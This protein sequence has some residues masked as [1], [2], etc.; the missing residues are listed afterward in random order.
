MLAVDQ[1]M[2]LRERKKQRTRATLTAAALRLFEEQGYERTTI[3]EIAAAADVSTRTFF[4]YFAGKDDVVF[5]DD[6]TERERMLAVVRACAPRQS[7]VDTL[8]SVV[9]DKLSG[10]TDEVL[11]LVP[12]ILRFVQTVPALR[13]AAL[14]RIERSQNALTDALAEHYPDIDRVDLAIAVGTVF[15]ALRA[16]SITSLD[17]GDEPGCVL[18]AGRRALAVAVDG[19]HATFGG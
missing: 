5:R 11:L 18:A 8:V 15:G 9:E 2:G 16:A 7:V 1:P 6:D 17:R 4:S 13:A 12:A 19:L 14:S 10:A 3:A